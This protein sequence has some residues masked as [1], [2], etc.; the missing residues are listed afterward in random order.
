MKEF[1]PLN[2]VEKVSESNFITHFYKKPKDIMTYDEIKAINDN[3]LF[4][5]L[6]P[7]PSPPTIKQDLPEFKMKML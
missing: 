6:A 5:N 7:L 1:S 4:C 2:F 3:A